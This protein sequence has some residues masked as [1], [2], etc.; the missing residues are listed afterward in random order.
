MVLIVLFFNIL[1]NGTARVDSA[2]INSTGS[3]LFGGVGMCGRVV[4]NGCGWWKGYIICISF[5]DTI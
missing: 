1:F 4:S 5:Q 2:I 3:L